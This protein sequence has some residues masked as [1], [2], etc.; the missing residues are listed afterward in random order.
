MHCLV[1]PPADIDNAAAL[2]DQ[3][4]HVLTDRPRARKIGRQRCGGLLRAKSISLEGN[5]CIRATINQA[6]WAFQTRVC[7]YRCQRLNQADWAHEA[8]R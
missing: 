5:A 6:D 7:L 3:R 8:L 1:A 4:Q 2:W